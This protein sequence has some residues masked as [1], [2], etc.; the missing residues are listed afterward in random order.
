MLLLG[1][2]NAP[3]DISCLE[4]CPGAGRYRSWESNVKPADM[5]FNLFRSETNGVEARRLA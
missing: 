1:T 4:G 3:W 2:A 5:G